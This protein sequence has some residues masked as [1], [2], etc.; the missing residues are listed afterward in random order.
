MQTLAQYLGSILGIH[1]L[2]GPDILDA[3]PALV[4][5]V[6]RDPGPSSP[7]ADRSRAVEHLNTFC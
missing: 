3:I 4:S 2:M 1:S 6:I 5:L 7:R